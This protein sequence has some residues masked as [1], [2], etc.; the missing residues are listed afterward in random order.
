M[1]KNKQIDQTVEPSQHSV[2]ETQ[3]FLDNIQQEFEEE[4]IDSSSKPKADAE[5]NKSPDEILQTNKM[6]DT[7]PLDLQ[8]P[9]KFLNIIV[10]KE[11][12]RSNDDDTPQFQTRAQKERLVK[13]DQNLSVLVQDTGKQSAKK[14]DKNMKRFGNFLIEKSQESREEYMKY[15]SEAPPIKPDIDVSESLS[16]TSSEDSV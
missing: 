6:A 14:F 16:E 1:E 2:K 13:S 8:R 9:Q 3:K 10:N 15:W 11:N 4:Q 5:P 12:Q 7:E